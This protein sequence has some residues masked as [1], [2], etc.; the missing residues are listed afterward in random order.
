MKTHLAVVRLV[1]AGWLPFCA[2]QSAVSAANPIEIHG[3]GN[4]NRVDAL[5][6]AL[7]AGLSPGAA[8]IVVER[9]TVVLKRGYGLADIESRRAI[10]PDTAFLLASVTKQFT[11]MAIMIL[12]E[13]GELKLDDSLS[14]FFFDF[15]RY[16][17]DITVRRLLNHTAGLPEYGALFKRS[18]L[19]D[20][21]WPRS[22]KRQRSS[23]EPTSKDALKLLAGE[24]LRFHPG[25]KFEYSN[26]GYVVL[27]QVVEKV[28]GQSFSHF[29]R[30]KIFEPLGMERTLLYDESRPKVSNVAT[31]YAFEHGAFEDIDYSPLNLIYGPDNI[32]TTVED[33]AKWERAL[34]T[35]KLVPAARLNEA[36]TPGKLNNGKLARYGTIGGKQTYYGFGWLI[37]AE[38]VYHPGGWLGYRTAILRFSKQHLTVIVLA[39]SAKLHP[40][41]IAERI[42]AIYLSAERADAAT[43]G[44]GIGSHSLQSLRRT[45]QFASRAGG[46][47]RG[48][49]QWRGT[50]ALRRSEID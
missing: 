49:D 4:G 6:S 32:Y 29:L 31:S 25:D 45:S 40:F 33:M 16:G 47:R 13:R 17:Q 38:K 46:D 35:N 23:Y 21:D 1:I 36:F 15:S 39:N 8:V 44:S 7:V 43:T 48:K 9:G 28:S 42:S 30:E 2:S 26:S 22:A 41:D 27:A 10:T 18:R 20:R 37:D 11:A 50:P 14:T 19:I 3:G 34:Y 5:V 12:A 24:K